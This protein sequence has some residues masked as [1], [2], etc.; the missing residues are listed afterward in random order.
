MV[1]RLF[2]ARGPWV[3]WQESLDDANK[4]NANTIRWGAPERNRHGELDKGN[5]GNWDTL[6]LG[7]RVY[8][9]NQ[10]SDLGPFSKQVIF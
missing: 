9:A 10:L 8:F 5:K 7:D 6:Q 3:N 1:D 4:R 2:M